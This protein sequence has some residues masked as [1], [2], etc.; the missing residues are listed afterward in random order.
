MSAAA[1]AERKLDVEVDTAI[2]DR[3]ITN[4]MT[5]RGLRR[6]VREAMAMKTV[7]DRGKAEAAL[8]RGIHYLL[9]EVV[10]VNGYAI[11]TFGALQFAY[12]VARP[13]LRADMRYGQKEMERLS[14]TNPSDAPLVYYALAS[15]LFEYCATKVEKADRREA[16]HGKQI[17]EPMVP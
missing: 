10:S 5:V 6:V 7:D 4:A 16:K 2:G 15:D 1:A 11:G 9:R 3:P 12:N 8:R 14:E 17:V 13:E